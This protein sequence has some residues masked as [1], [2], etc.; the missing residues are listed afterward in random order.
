MPFPKLWSSENGSAA[1]EFVMVVIPTTLLVLPLFGLFGLMQARVVD[2]QLA[3]EIARFAALADVSEAEARAYL[4]KV[5]SSA[6]LS[7]TGNSDDCSVR[8]SIYREVEIF[9][10]PSVI[11]LTSTGKVSCEVR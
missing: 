4:A 9:G 3:Y 8:A 11:G 10:W 2:G 7:L 1:A 6:K 5:N